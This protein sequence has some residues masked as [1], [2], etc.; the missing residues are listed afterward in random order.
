MALPH[1]R[2]LFPLPASFEIE[3]RVTLHAPFFG[4]PIEFIRAEKTIDPLEFA[5]AKG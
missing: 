5:K 3:N 1:V 4:S 2:I